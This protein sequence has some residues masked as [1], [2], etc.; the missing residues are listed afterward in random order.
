MLRT[1][2]PLDDYVKRLIESYDE[3]RVENWRG[4]D[5]FVRPD[6]R[7]DIT[8]ADFTALKYISDWLG[9]SNKHQLV[10]LGDV[11]SGKSTLLRFLAYNLAQ[12]Y[13]KDPV[14]HPAPVLI[15][16]GEVHK[17]TTLKAIVDEHFSL[18][19]FDNVTPQLPAPGQRRQDHSLLRR[20]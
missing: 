2:A 5:W 20:L 9:Q 7:Q 10:I 17:E 16:L 14:R 19:D 4:E 1:L 6:V 15:P 18:R 11:G 13:L 8:G 12:Q 3:W